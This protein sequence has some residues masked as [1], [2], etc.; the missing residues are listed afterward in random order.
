MGRTAN[1]RNEPTE[2]VPIT[3]EF[4]GHLQEAMQQANAEARQMAE[5][6][7]YPGALTVDAVDENCRVSARRSVESMLQLGASLCILK[8]LTAHGD[9]TARVEAMGLHPRSA[10]QF[11]GAAL[12]VAKTEKNSVLL[13]AGNTSKLLELVT[14]DDE[15]LNELE[16]SNDLDEISRMTLSD[17]RQRLRKAERAAELHRKTAEDTHAELTAL[18]ASKKVV[19]DTDW[20]DALEVVSDQVAA[21]GRKAFTGLTELEACRIHLFDVGNALPEEEQVKY[22]AALG[23]VSE[24]YERALER[25]ERAVAKERLTFDKTLGAY[26]PAPGSKK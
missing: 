3:K 19:A 15:V 26:A 8:A 23:F 14:V 17:L 22:G 7:R 11:M 1:V 9:F 13:A 12:R 2:L 10:R 18:K 24:V 20:P 4:N 16:K 5:L 21:A 25:I 6:F